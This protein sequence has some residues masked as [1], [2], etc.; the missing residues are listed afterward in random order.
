MPTIQERIH[1]LAEHFG[2]PFIEAILNRKNGLDIAD[3]NIICNRSILAES[4]SMIKGFRSVRKRIV[5]HFPQSLGEP[6]GEWF[7]L[8]AGYMLKSIGESPIFEKK[9]ME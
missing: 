2:K 1:L 3:I 9:V 7:Q 4:L 5:N 8:E 6:R